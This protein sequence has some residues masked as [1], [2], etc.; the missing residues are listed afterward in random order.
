VSTELCADKLSRRQGVCAVGRI[1]LLGLVA[2]LSA[3]TRPP[4]PPLAPELQAIYCPINRTE[5]ASAMFA[6]ARITFVCI[7]KQLAA[8]PYLLRCDLQ[9]RPMICEDEGSLLF[10]RSA[11]GDVYA[12]LLPEE[13]RRKDASAS[14][15][16][17]SS[18]LT[19]NF[20]KLPPSRSTFEEVETN[21]R[22]LLSDREVLLPS[23]FT[24]AKGTLCD[25]KATVL[26]SGVCNLEVRSASL[27]WHVAVGIHADSGTP[28]SA[29]EYRGELAF[30]L[31]L[32]GRLVRDPEK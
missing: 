9:S 22:F 28:V 4:P 20:R 8:S 17:G 21:W 30:W 16:S 27:Y 13:L 2:S 19:V 24:F 23:G 5:H 18:R 10:S 15:L 26:N 12:G 6:R 32:L 1:V 25:R 7:S 31:K 3:C 29:E 14:G 11:A